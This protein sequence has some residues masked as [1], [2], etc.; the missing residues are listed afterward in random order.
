MTAPLEGEPCASLASLFRGRWHPEGV[1]EGVYS[2]EV[3]HSPSHGWHRDSP[4]R[5]GAK[6]PSGLPEFQGLID[7]PNANQALTREKCMS[8]RLSEAHGGI[9]APIFPQMSRKCV[10]P[11]TPLTLRMTGWSETGK[12]A[13]P[14]HC[15]DTRTHSNLDSYSEFRIIYF[16]TQKR[17]K[18]L[19]VMSSRTVAP[20]TSPMASMASSTSMRTM[21]AVSPSCSPFSD[22]SMAS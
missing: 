19:A 10:D 7:I 11:S 5:E 8:S 6:A 17:S 2:Q 3:P 22:R 9:L 1:T 18:I 4:L 15:V 21:S 13:F 14:V 16:P 12:T 20:V